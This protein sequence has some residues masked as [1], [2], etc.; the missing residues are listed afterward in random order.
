[1]KAMKINTSTLLK[2]IEDGYL[3]LITSL[4]STNMRNWPVWLKMQSKNLKL[5]KIKVKLHNLKERQEILMN[6][7]SLVKNEQDLV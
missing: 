7:L 1:M 2:D 6:N 3:N 4:W 5:V